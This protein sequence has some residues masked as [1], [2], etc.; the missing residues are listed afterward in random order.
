MKSIW[1]SGTCRESAQARCSV[2]WKLT[3]QALSGVCCAAAM[4]DTPARWTQTSGMPVRT[5]A[6]TAS[7]SRT[8]SGRVRR[9]AEGYAPTNAVIKW[10][11]TKPEAPVTNMLRGAGVISTLQTR[12]VALQVGIHHLR[13]HVIQRYGRPPTKLLLGLPGIAKQHINFG[14]PNQ[15]ATGDDVILEIQPGIVESNAAEFAYLGGTAGGDHVVVRRVLLQHQPH[16]LDIVPRV[17]PVAHRLE[18]AERQLS[19]Q[20]QFDARNAV[21][22]LTGDKLDTPQRAFMVEQNPRGR[23][24]AEALAVVHCHPM[25]IELGSRIRRAR[26]ERRGL[27]LPRLPDTAEHLGRRCLVKASLRPRDA[28]CLQHIRCA[29]T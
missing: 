2:P 9:V 20:A 1:Q 29:D 10:R 19:G 4:A 23:M 11:P 28:Y 25:C 27:G 3:F 8:S 26:I 22:N 21:R 24:H 14:R 15:V 16:S 17:A 18:I 5:A 12:L 6:S 7:A 13:D